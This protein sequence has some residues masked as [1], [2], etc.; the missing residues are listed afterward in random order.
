[1]TQLRL[2]GWSWVSKGWQTKQA[3]DLFSR[4]ETKIQSLNKEL[5][6]IR[7]ELNPKADLSESQK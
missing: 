2:S 1:M 3:K 5:E 7:E 4:S 6:K